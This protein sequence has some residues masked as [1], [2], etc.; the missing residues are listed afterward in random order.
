MTVA[1]TAGATGGGEPVDGADRDTGGP[2]DRDQAG[3]R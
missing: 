2:S 1:A 3:G